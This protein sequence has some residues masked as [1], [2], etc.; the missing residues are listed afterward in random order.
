LREWNK[1]TVQKFW[2]FLK[3]LKL[4]IEFILNFI[5]LH[6][7]QNFKDENVDPALLAKAIL[8]LVLRDA[9]HLPTFLLL[10]FQGFL[11]VFPDFAFAVADEI[12]Q[13]QLVKLN[14]PQRLTFFTLSV[15]L[16]KYYLLFQCV[17]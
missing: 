12:S 17:A 15:V 7:L 14:I 8:D 1:K 3:K 16:F 11:K 6:F 13:T 5:L 10:W 4:K 2:R 9:L